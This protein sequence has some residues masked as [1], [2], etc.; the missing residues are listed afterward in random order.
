M[1]SA[2]F[3]IVSFLLFRLSRLRKGGH[4]C[5]SRRVHQEPSQP[6]TVTINH[7]VTAIAFLVCHMSVQRIW[8]QRASVRT[9]LRGEAS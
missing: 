5:F 4:L 8:T 3:C 6:L 7:I 2:A 1:I 9:E